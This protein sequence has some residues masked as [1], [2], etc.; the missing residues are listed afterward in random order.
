LSLRYDDALSHGGFNPNTLFF[1]P[2]Y[3][4]PQSQHQQARR[5]QR[6]RHR[7]RRRPRHQRRS[8]HT[9]QSPAR[10]SCLT[11]LHQLRLHRRCH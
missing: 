7:H 9:E 6:P 5:R 4:A 2:T 10:S 1:S 3:D 11:G 8:S